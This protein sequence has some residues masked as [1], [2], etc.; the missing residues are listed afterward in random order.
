LNIKWRGHCRSF[1]DLPRGDLPVEAVKFKEPSSA[2]TLNICALLF[3]VP[4]FFL[5]KICIGIKFDGEKGIYDLMNNWGFLGSLLMVL[6][7]EFLHAVAFPKGSEIGIWYSAKYVV[8]FVHSTAT[9]SKGRFI[10]ISLLPNIVFGFLPFFLWV[11]LPSQAEGFSNFLF[12]FSFMS[13][14]F[15]AGDYMNVFNAAVQMPRNT[16]TQLSGFHSYW[17]Y[18]SRKLKSF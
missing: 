18:P 4:I 7:H 3:A 8:A 13:M 10:F 9:T 11:I 17:F 5:V 12:T 2:L 15:G 1:D 6:P 14:L 16:Q